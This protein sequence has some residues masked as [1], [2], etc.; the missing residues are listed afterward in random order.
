MSYHLAAIVFLALILAFIAKIVLEPRRPRVQDRWP[1]YACPVMT[2]N[3]RDAYTRLQAAAPGYPASHHRRH[4]GGRTNGPE[5]DR[6]QVGI[7]ARRDSI[8]LGSIG[9]VR[10]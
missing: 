4:A 7:C 8:V 10:W 6:G 1:L 5:A 9:F 3:E 2:A